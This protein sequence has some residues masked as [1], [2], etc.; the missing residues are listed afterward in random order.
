MPPGSKFRP[1]RDS[2]E[3]GTM[4]FG[5]PALLW[6][7]LVLPFLG[8]LLIHNDRRRQ[9][10]LEKLVAAR[11]L[12]RLTDPIAQGRQIMKRILFLGAMAAFLLALARPQVG[13]IEQNFEQHGRDIVLAIDTS[14][15]MLSTD[16]V[17]N[18]LARAKLVAQDVLDAMKGDRFGLIAFAGAAQVEAPLTVDYQTVLDAITQLDTKTVE[19]GGT[20]ITSAIHAAELALGKSEGSYR[21]MVLLTDGEDLEEDS[22]AAAK[23]AASS[24]IR[25]F[26]V[27]IGTKEG[28]TI[29]VDPDHQELLRDHSGQTV[30]SH[31]DEKRLQEIAEQSGGFYVHL[32]NGSTARL[33]GSGLSKLSEG[34]IDERSTRTPVERYRW[35]SAIGLML[36]LISAALRDRRKETRPQRLP[37]EKAVAA[38]MLGLILNAH[39]NPALDRYDQGDFDGA[40]QS[41]REELKH[42]PDSPRINFNL[43]DAAFRLQKY[44]EAFEAY[45]KAMVSSDPTLQEKA[46]YNAGNALFL[47]GNHAQD[48]EQQL[49][50]YYDARYQY[51]Q[52]LDRNSGDDQAKKNLS[53]LEER[54]KEAEKEKQEQQQRQRSQQRQSQ[55]KHKSQKRDKQPSDQGQNPQP[56]SEPG[57]GQ[58]AP[59]DQQTPGGQE[60]NPAQ[61]E[62]GDDDDPPQSDPTPTPNKNGQLREITPSDETK[63][64]MPLPEVSQPGTMSENEALGLLDSLKD[65]SDR[66]DLM[67]RKTERGIVRDW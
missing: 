45:S 32:E 63:G 5:Q 11:L 28:S 31:L 21:A 47:E 67:H 9:R 38:T 50:N 46:Y 7:L 57:S 27:G 33:I 55:R 56:K 49:S 43:G 12:P 34:K 44:D 19:R 3:Q 66:I 51:H 15:S 61:S 16:Y 58:S 42:D 62:E 53:L 40:L 24:G 10:R 13:S 2:L 39:A 17:P 23:E 18:R 29:P 20:D 35:P 4:T 22:V 41:L 6:C 65:E 8:A 64:Q 60:Q 36:L 14:R 25:I 1:E 30:R 52:A 26:T 54:I 59:D 48:L 37:V